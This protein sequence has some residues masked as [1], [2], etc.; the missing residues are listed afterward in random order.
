MAQ[1]KDISSCLPNPVLAK[2]RSQQM[3]T[4]MEQSAKAP[5]AKERYRIA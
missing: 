1:N 2:W 4:A 5:T 3:L